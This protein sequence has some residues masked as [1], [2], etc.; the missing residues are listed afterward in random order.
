[1]NYKIT[2]TIKHYQKNGTKWIETDSTTSDITEEHYHNATD[3]ATVRFF[4]NLGGYERVEKSY[5]FA[6]YVPIRI[7]SI[8]PCRTEKTVRDY[9]F[10]M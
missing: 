1:M 2:E 10:S 7:T 3:P 9:Q 5:T 6:G 4:R 8:S